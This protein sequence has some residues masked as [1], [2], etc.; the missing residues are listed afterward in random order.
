AGQRR[1]LRDLEDDAMSDP[2]ERR[3]RREQVVIHEIT[4]VQVDE[5]ERVA[6]AG[7]K[8]LRGA[9]AHCPAEG[10]DLTELLAHAED[11]R[12]RGPPRIGGSKQRL[13]AE[14]ATILCLDD[15]LVSHPQ[16]LDDLAERPPQRRYLA[17]LVLDR[18]QEL[19]RDLPLL[20]PAVLLGGLLDRAD[21]LLAL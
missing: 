2:R 3:V 1:P 19:Q 18:A 12:R 20:D 10:V 5:Q 17:T 4:G 14:E 7:G 15:R 16:L 6:G 9:G 11:G 8:R 21:Q 13:V